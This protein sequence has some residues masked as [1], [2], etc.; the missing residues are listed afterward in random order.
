M[1]VMVAAGISLLAFAAITAGT[2]VL[3][4]QRIHPRSF[5]MSFLTSAGRLHESSGE[6]LPYRMFEPRAVPAGSTVP[7]VVVLHSAYESGTNNVSQLT[8]TVRLF[9]SRTYQRIRKAYIVAPQSPAG[10]QW[11]DLPPKHAP[12]VNYDMSSIDVSWRE[13]AVDQLIEELIATHPIDPDRISI[14]GESMGATGT[15]DM[16]YRYPDRFAAAVTL[17]GRADPRV[18]PA[19]AHIAIRSFHGE[20][21]P[22]SPV[23]NSTSMVDALMQAGADAELTILDAAHGIAHRTWTEEL[24]EWM[25]AQRRSGP[26]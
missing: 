20:H 12:L 18:A 8:A 15:W 1:R 22:L 16:L 17:N 21:D 11:T 10:L 7:L 2:W 23:T 25:T 6:V 9:T 4:K 13:R 19:I 26:E 5:L 24:Y 3:G 14:T